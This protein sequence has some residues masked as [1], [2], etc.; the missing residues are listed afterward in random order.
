MFVWFMYAKGTEGKNKV[1]NAG[2][3]AYQYNRFGAVKLY[4]T[5]QKHHGRY[6]IARSFTFLTL[7]LTAWEFKK[8]FL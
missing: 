5:L 4:M 1:T 2:A 6:I 8:P 3:A 7:I